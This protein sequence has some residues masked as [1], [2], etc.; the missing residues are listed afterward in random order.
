M[1]INSFKGIY[2]H[3]YLQQ[4]KVKWETLHCFFLKF[5]LITCI[6]DQGF[7]YNIKNCPMD[8]KNIYS[9]NRIWCMMQKWICFKTVYQQTK[10][11]TDLTNLICPFH[12]RGTL[13][14]TNSSLLWIFSLQK[15]PQWDITLKWQIYK[16]HNPFDCI[17]HGT[18]N[19][20]MSEVWKL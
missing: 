20:I 6:N 10:F 1:G 3:L 12:S 2:L 16:K 8:N 15:A 14:K 18:F 9:I 19:L 13:N 17:S 11:T 7:L 4:N 5:C